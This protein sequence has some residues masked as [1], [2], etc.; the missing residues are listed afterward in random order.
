MLTRL[1]VYGFKNLVDVDVRFGPFTCIAGPNGVGKSNLFDA[2]HFLSLLA[3]R[4]LLDAALEVRGARTAG[5]RSLFHRSGPQ[6]AEEMS[7]EVEMIVPRMGRDDLGQEATATSTFLRYALTLG[8][9]RDAASGSLGGLEVLREQ[10]QHIPKGEAHLHLLFTHKV[11]GWRDSAIHSRRWTPFYISTIDEGNARVVKVHQDG[12]GGLP[13]SYA[14]ATLPRTAL[15]G[16]NAAETPTAL[17]ARREMQSWRILQLEPSALRRPDPFTAPSV[18]GADGSHLAT[19]LYRLA[20]SAEAEDVYAEVAN[21]LSEL[22]EDVRRVSV[23]RDERRELLTVQVETRD[24]TTFPSPSLSDGSLRFLALAVLE[25]DPEARWVVCLEEPEN[26]VHPERLPAILHLLQDI[27]TDPSLPVDEDNPLRQVLVNTHSPAVVQLVPDDS[28]LVAK[29]S[30]V[31]GRQVP[32]SIGAS[33]RPLPGTWRDGTEG[34]PLAISLGDLLAYLNPS[35][36]GHL[37]ML[38]RPRSVVDR[39]DVEQ[40]LLF[41][42]GGG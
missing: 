37:R 34:A 24:G 1:K 21:R 40:F 39:A 19:T 41:A 8:Y 16:A 42:R 18:M 17:L 20:H 13:R 7:F 36:L 22:Y 33:F 32:P 38:D 9:R 15:S 26:G 31:V 29:A 27:A 5:V 4:T 25:A 35:S 11:R 3:E 28:L 30:E 2:I 12:G 14:A 6:F 10:L 23:E